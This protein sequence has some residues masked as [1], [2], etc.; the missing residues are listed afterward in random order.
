MA[1]YGDR[2]PLPNALCRAAVRDVA[3]PAGSSIC[4]LRDDLPILGD[5]RRRPIPIRPVRRATWARI[6]AVPAFSR[7]SIAAPS[8][9]LCRQNINRSKGRPKRYR[10][11][12]IA[13]SSITPQS[14]G[15]EPSSA[16]TIDLRRPAHHL[17]P[18]LMLPVP[19]RG[20]WPTM[21]A[22]IRLPVALVDRKSRKQHTAFDR[23]ALGATGAG[24]GVRWS[25]SALSPDFPYNL[26]GLIGFNFRISE[27]TRC[28]CLFH[29]I[30]KQLA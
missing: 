1:A 26:N 29:R 15:P 25:S 22:G 30:F 23:V 12:F 11:G 13:P 24:E 2:L 10:R 17:S 19:V 3:I 6:P 16:Q 18:S 28:H 9:T 21:R 27:K 5:R 14:S 8:S 20:T 4:D 7:H